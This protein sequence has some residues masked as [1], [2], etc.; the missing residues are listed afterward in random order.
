MHFVGLTA[1]EIT[2]AFGRSQI[3]NR[4]N[5]QSPQICVPIRQENGAILKKPGKGR[6]KWALAGKTR[7]K[8]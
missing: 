4:G 6:G 5:S 1:Q 2:M 3:D 7:V 8:H